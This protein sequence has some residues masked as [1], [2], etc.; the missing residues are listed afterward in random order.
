M[1]KK[2]QVHLLV[3]ADYKNRWVHASREA[4]MRLSDWITEAVEAHMNIKGVSISLPDG[5]EQEDMGQGISTAVT[6][7]LHI[8][9][10][11]FI[12]C[13]KEVA[14][15]TARVNRAKILLSSIMAFL[16]VMI[17][18]L[19]FVIFDAPAETKDLAFVSCMLLGV[20]AIGLLASCS[21]DNQATSLDEISRNT[22]L[23]G[24][25]EHIRQNFSML[26]EAQEGVILNSQLEAILAASRLASR[27]EKIEALMADRA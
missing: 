24:R 23:I 10:V 16:V 8:Q 5:R 27:A 25:H 3:P 9:T 18:L 21:E 19:G 14:N 6:T 7:S 13:A 4:G 22:N 20:F 2:A 26:Y 17:G 15:R 12:P 11:A 1:T